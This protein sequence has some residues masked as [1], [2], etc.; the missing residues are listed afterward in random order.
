ML[1]DVDAPGARRDGGRERDLAGEL[2]RYVLREG[3]GA[4]LRFFWL[5]LLG[6]RRSPPAMKCA[7]LLQHTHTQHT[8]TG[9][10]L[11]QQ[12]GNHH[13]SPPPLPTTITCAC[14]S[15]TPK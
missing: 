14:L 1:L 4:V 11:K 10:T 3:E 7:R 8:Q 5:L 6:R 2:L 12:P 15:A 13:Q 9:T